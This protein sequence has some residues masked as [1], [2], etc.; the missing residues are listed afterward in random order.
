[1][2]Q[3]NNPAFVKWMG[4]CLGNVHEPA[5]GEAFMAHFKSALLQY[6]LS[7]RAQG[8][9]GEAVSPPVDAWTLLLL[10]TPQAGACGGE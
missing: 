7:A 5:E 1:M 2:G 9:R 4:T 8:R 10:C 3:P 6:A